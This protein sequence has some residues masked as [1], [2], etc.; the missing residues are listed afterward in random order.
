MRALTVLG[1]QTKFIEQIT[2]ITQAYRLTQNYKLYKLLFILCLGQREQKHSL[3]SST[4][5]Y[6]SYTCKGVPP[7]PPSPQDYDLHSQISEYQLIMFRK[8]QETHF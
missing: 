6:L 5:P 2:S 1:V 7:P 8:F 3:F 4:S